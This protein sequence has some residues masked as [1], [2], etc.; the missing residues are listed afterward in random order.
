[1]SEQEPMSDEELDAIRDHQ[2][3]ASTVDDWQGMPVYVQRLETV[4]QND[5]PRLLAE[6]DRLRA[7]NA[8][9]RPIV[10]AVADDDGERVGKRLWDIHEQAR[11]LLAKEGGE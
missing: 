1:M 2:R 5:M 6:V 11:A 7:E 4:A 8:V 10:A 9:M 3:A